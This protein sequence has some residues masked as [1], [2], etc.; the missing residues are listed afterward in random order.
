MSELD[1]LAQQ[2]K[3]HRISRRDFLGRA[4]ALGVSIAA[5]GTLYSTALK[6]ATPNQGGTVRIGVNGG[7]SSDALDPATYGTQVHLPLSRSWADQLVVVSPED[8]SPQPSLAESWEPSDDV[9]T[10]VFKIRQGVTFHNGKELD[11]N[12]CAETLRR[13]SDPDSVSGALGLFKGFESIEATDANTLTIK[14]SSPNADLPLF[15]TDY[16]LQMQPNGGR[17]DPNA[18]IGT[19]PYMLKEV[20]HGVRY[21]LEKNPNYWGDDSHFDGVEILILNDETA[22]MAAL[23]SGQV[24][25]VNR[26]P[27]RTAGLLA[28]APGIKIENV[29]GRGHY[30]FIMHCNTAPFDN[31]D[32]RMALKLAIDREAMVQTVLQGY[33]TV[34]NDFPINAAYDLFPEQIEQ[35]TYDPEKA[36]FHYKKSG[37]EGPILIR[38]SDS[39]FPGAV[40]ATVLYQQQAQAAGIQLEILQEPSDGYWENVWNVQPFCA[41]YWGGRP[42]Q[43]QM[44]STAY[45]STADWNDTRFFRPEFDNVI[46]AAR[47]ELDRAKRAELYAEAATMVRDDGGLILPMFNDW[48]DGRNEKLQGY[49]LDPSFEMSGGYVSRRCWFA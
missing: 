28:R 46:D 27:P 17:D 34:G 18:G 49:V 42:T 30:V 19:G 24:D 22:R 10:W 32:L 40:D 35:R 1:F 6:A 13:H 31:V 23:Q 41:S 20:E 3:R 21:G 26:V 36:A 2:V 37:H 5:A 38:T 44:Y 29:G 9:K 14:L 43:D 7:E 16:H 8:G 12:D 4:S 39:A 15:F 25:V 48:V 45:V 33:G 47:G 11:A